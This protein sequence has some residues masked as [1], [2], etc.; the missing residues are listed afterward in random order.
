M[1]TDFVGSILANK[2][3]IYVNLIGTDVVWNG[4]TTAK[5]TAAMYVAETSETDKTITI[6]YPGAVSNA[7]SYRFEVGS[8]TAGRFDSTALTVTVKGEVTSISRQT[9]SIH[10][11]TTITI[12]GGPFSTDP[13][14]NPVQIGTDDCIVS[15]S[16]TTE[17]VC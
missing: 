6:K 14:D 11:G 7:A 16:T 4:E 5:T 2:D 3:E 9:G 15:S 10:G 8:T 17:I 12:G 1:A 13:L